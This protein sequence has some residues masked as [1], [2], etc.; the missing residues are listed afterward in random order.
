MNQKRRLLQ[1]IYY[2]SFVVFTLTFSN[3]IYAQPTNDLC[4]FAIK[5]PSADNFCSLD[6]QFTNVGATPDTP[7]GQATAQC[8][9]I[10]WQNGVW[11]SFVPREPA[12]LIKVFGF[13]QGGTLRNP[14]ILLFSSCNEFLSC[15]PGREIGVDEFLYDDLTIGQNYF[16]MVESSVGDEGTFKLCIND[17][18]PTPAPE[19]D[20]VNAVVLCDKTPFVVESLEGSGQDKNEIEPGNCIQEEFQSSW[21]K[22]TCDQAGPLTFT[23]T[24]NNHRG[25]NFISDDLDFALYELPGGLNDCANKRLLRCMASGSNGTPLA[26]WIDCNGPTG[27]RFGET[28]IT[29]TAGCA[30]GDNNFVSPL[31]MEAG[32]SYVLIV[33]NFSRSGLGF[34]IEF[35]GTGTFLGPE[36]DFDIFAQNAFECDKTITFTD[37][38]QSL[39]DPISNYRWNFGNRAVPSRE[40]GVGPYDVVYASFGTK[41]AALTV[42]TTR[43]CNVTKIVDFF[44]EPCCRDTSTLTLGGIVKNL[45]CFNEPEGE[46][47]ASVIRGGTEEF[48]Y[49]LDG[50]TFQP[51]PLF[52]NLDIGEYQLSV[53]DIKGCRHDTIFVIVEPPPVI[54]DAGEDQ[55]IVLGDSTYLQGF[56]IQ[57]V[58]GVGSSSWNPLT[59]VIE[60][61]SL[62]FRVF[63][64]PKD[65][66]SYIFTVTDENGCTGTDIVT[67]R[68]RKEY[69]LYAPNIIK[70][71]KNRFR[72][73]FF[74]VFGNGAVR[75]I[76][77][78][79]V[80]D[81]WGNLVYQGSDIRKE[82]ESLIKFKF[83]VQDDGWD[84]EFAGKP[85]EQGVFAWRA[86][87][88]YIDDEVKNFSGSLTVIREE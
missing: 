58:N 26:D 69:N 73:N 10:R 23:L 14:K 38:S 59:D 62:N 70:I 61:D 28:D 79:E 11:F 88:T 46:I 82:D 6:G 3:L 52:P 47:L 86:M 57:S 43:G 45:I 29:E 74:N 80:Y 36:V 20:C 76:D 77:L 17:F 84:G 75:H 21:Y 19:S 4:Q 44:V 54:V 85:V 39:T 53:I 1:K 55:S 27:L 42:T 37:K 81:R 8:I 25:R 31:N 35:G 72:N 33:N 32:K 9:S 30:R 7:F 48:E 67:I 78:L 71:G 63:L 15:S 66:T 65:E 51:N 64:Y 12:V 18:V 22:W 40:N 49:S 13:G 87:V 41:T 2:F 24:P 83:S 34:S 16:I 50:I 60:Y 5:I 68:V 56:L